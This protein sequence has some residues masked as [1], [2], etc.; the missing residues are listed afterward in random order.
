MAPQLSCT[1]WRND[2]PQKPRPETRPEGL[3]DSKGGA[4]GGSVR[5]WE[6]WEAPTAAVGLAQGHPLACRFLCR[7]VP[8]CGWIS[9]ARRGPCWRLQRPEAHLSA[10]RQLCPR[11][12]AAEARAHLPRQKR[13]WGGLRI[14]A[15]SLSAWGNP[16]AVPPPRPRRCPPLPIRWPS[17]WPPFWP[18]APSP[19]PGRAPA[20]PICPTPAAGC[21]GF[22]GWCGAARSLRG[23]LRSG[24]GGPAAKGPHP[25]AMTL[26]PS[27]LWWAGW[28]ANRL[29]PRLALLLPA[30]ILRA[31]YRQLWRDWAER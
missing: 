8:A 29:P 9:P 6:P 26:P 14:A 16:A 12:G 20:P 15:V 25:E 17:C 19:G 30:P 2:S 23:W 1:S 31:A 3:P 21:P 28:L 24:R 22:G 4:A 7:P 5:P 11:P 10:D 18:I 13:R 27:L